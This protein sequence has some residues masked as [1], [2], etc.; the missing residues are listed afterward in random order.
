MKKLILTAS[1]TLIPVIALMFLAC[2]G[3]C[4]GPEKIFGDYQ[5]DIYEDAKTQMNDNFCRQT[6]RPR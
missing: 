1:V 2:S 6:P 4:A 3:Y 5:A